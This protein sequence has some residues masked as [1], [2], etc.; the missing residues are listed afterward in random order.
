MYPFSFPDYNL[1]VLSMREQKKMQIMFSD[2][3]TRGEYLAEDGTCWKV[4]LFYIA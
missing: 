4:I 2:S 3:R 1:S